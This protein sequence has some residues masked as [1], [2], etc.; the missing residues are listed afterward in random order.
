M[1]TN[2]I[3]VNGVLSGPDDGSSAF[4]D[5]LTQEQ[6]YRQ[7]LVNAGFNPTSLQWLKLPTPKTAPFKIETV[8][9]LVPGDDID[10]T[11]KGTISIARIESY[12]EQFNVHF[13]GQITMCKDKPLQHH[14]IDFMGRLFH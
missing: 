10:E 3:V 9:V 7:S 6:G 14:G 12:F 8:I 1:K 4:F 13:E 11:G 5:L 2:H